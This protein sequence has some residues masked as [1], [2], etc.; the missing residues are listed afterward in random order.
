MIASSP[1]READGRLRH[2]PEKIAELIGDIKPSLVYGPQSR[3]LDQ[4]RYGIA[5]RMAVLRTLCDN[6]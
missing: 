6:T 3:I 5:V 1:Q 4:V 2:M